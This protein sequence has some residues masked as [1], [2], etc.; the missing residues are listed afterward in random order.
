M[1]NWE[2]NKRKYI[3]KYKKQNYKRVPLDIAADYYRDIL[4][5]AAER[6][7]LPV[8]TFIKNAIQ[9]KIDKENNNII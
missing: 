4:K 7:G 5:P 9:E 2:I 1:K 3:E 6:A 8:N